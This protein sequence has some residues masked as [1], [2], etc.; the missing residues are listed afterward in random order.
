MHQLA[1]L[2]HGERSLGLA[3]PT[4]SSANN[5]SLSYEVEEKTQAQKLVEVVD[6]LQSLPPGMKVICSQHHSTNQKQN[7]LL[8]E[9]C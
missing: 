2:R 7:R 5:V 6:Y 4:L 9:T 8:Q 1:F 3:A